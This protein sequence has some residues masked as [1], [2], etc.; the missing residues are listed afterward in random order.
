MKFVTTIARSLQADMQAE[1]RD[2]ERALASGTRDAGRIL[3]TELR[4][5]VTSAGLGQR[6]GNSWRDKHYPNQK[7]DAAS[8]VYTKAPQIIRAFEEGAMIRSKRGRFLATRERRAS[9]S[10]RRAAA[11]ARSSAD[12]RSGSTSTL[13]Y[14]AWSSAS[15]TGAPSPEAD[16]ANDLS[17]AVGAVQSAPV[18]LGR[19]GE[20][21]DHGER[22]RRDRQPSALS[23]RRRT[24]ANALSTGCKRRRKNPSRVAAG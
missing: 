22:G 9:A 8:L 5:Q 21:E 18:A 7:L 3:R 4:R 20:L 17:E 16:T 19:P 15:V 14:G 6:L 1:L 11:S 24:V 23:V 12:I 2:I 10:L 13:R